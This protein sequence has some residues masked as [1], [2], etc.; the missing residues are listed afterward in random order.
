MRRLLALS[1][2]IALIAVT[3][4]SV[5]AAGKSS[6]KG[7]RTIDAAGQLHVT[8]KER[9][10]GNETLTYR[11]QAVG[12]ITWACGGVFYG[13]GGFGGPS[14]IDPN[15]RTTIT[16]VRGQAVGT[17]WHQTLLGATPSCP[18]NELGEI[19]PAVMSAT[20]WSEIT[21]TSSSGRV[22]RLR[23]ISRTF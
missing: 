6:F 12:L 9:G 8:F 22:L 16:A 17:L 10:V 15:Q 13:T 1:V 20:S 18:K 21:V 2:A 23:D 19:L 3:I 14:W 11:L 7:K 4:A 5:A